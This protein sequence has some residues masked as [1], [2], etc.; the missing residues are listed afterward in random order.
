MQAA[1]LPDRGV[2]KV[3]GDDAR[4]FL[5]GLVTTDMAKVTPADARFTAVLTP[6]GKIIVDFMIAEAP[7]EDG[8]GF[9]LDCPRALASTL[10]EK[11]NFYKLRAKVIC[12]D[13][14][15]VLGVM[16]VWDGAGNSEY[17][18][19]YPD[20]R[21]L[22]LGWRI[23]LPPHLAADAA[24]DL[25]A[26]LVDAEAYETHRIA[27]GVPRGGLDFIYSDTFPHEADMDQLNGV[28]FDKGCYVGQEVVSRVEH[29]A[30]ARSRVVP[31]AYDEFAPSSGLADHGKWKAGRTARLD[32]QGS[33]PRAPASRSCR[34]RDCQRHGA[35]SWRH[36]HPRREARLGEFRLAGQSEGRDMSKSVLHPDGINRCPWPKQDPLYV[37]YHD[38][39]WG[40]PEFDDRALYEKLVLDGFQAGLS[41]ITILRKR[42]NFRHAF[43]GFDPEK[44][45]RYQKRKTKSLMK[46]AG[47]VR[48]RAKIEG[49]I[50]SA[51]AWLEIMEKGP[52][53]SNFLWDHLDGKPKVNHFR[54][55]KQVPA[56][57]PA[58]AK[59]VERTHWT[60]FQ[61]CRADDRLCVHAGGWHGQRPSC[62]L[63]SPRPACE[64]Q[65]QA[66]TPKPARRGK[67]ALR[68]WQR[69]L[70]G[71]RLDLLDPSP[72]D[73]ELDDIAHGL[74]RVARWN[75]QTQGAH[76]FS[77]AQHSL[78]VEA[79]ARAKV[80]RL[81]RNARL[82]VLAA[83]RTGI[84]GR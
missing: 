21:L 27:L 76:I 1:L 47:I 9:F 3:V 82:A 75:G 26:T 30:S 12:E 81:D 2:V 61:I 6:Q 79:L 28:D 34:R 73:V 55:T 78:L 39:E 23:M 67:S 25:G 57:T 46:D 11:L 45:A 52:G 53:F 14:S 40:V 48:N 18:L 63:L 4:R 42:E 43:D 60:W 15:E 71:R 83:R 54:T 33:G 69:M 19:S 68:A 64:I 74:A 31:I 35:G 51:R 32:G 10:V 5:N 58:V 84:C 70:S 77:V 7:T 29:R 62:H 37:A 20:P 65:A 8:G 41:W 44:I 16:A 13:L 66:M 49:A 38:D 72:L 50:S 80:P 17:G 24:A 22:T 36:H 56:E 59:N